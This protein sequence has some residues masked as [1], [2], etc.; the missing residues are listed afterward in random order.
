VSKYWLGK[1]GATTASDDR[2]ISPPAFVSDRVSSMACSADGFEGKPA[3]EPSI[4]RSDFAFEYVS[5]TTS[6]GDALKILS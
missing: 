3:V 6:D 5:V 1:F 2:L 4:P